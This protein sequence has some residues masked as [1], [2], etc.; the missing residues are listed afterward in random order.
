MGSKQR[1]L[2]YFR[3]SVGHV[4]TTEELAYV[5]KGAKEF[6]RRSRELRTEDGY[7][8]A[9]RF[10]GRPDLGMGEYILL[11]AERIAEPHDRHIPEPV[12]KHVYERDRNT[13]R[14]CNWNQALWTPDDPRFLELHHLEAHETG[15]ENIERNLAVVCNKC[16]DDVHAGRREREITKL[17]EHQCRMYSK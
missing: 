2:A 11:S 17:R 15:G 9:T 13:C 10:T 7:A 5:A 6:A 3:E 12:Q 16:H 14:L 8:I 1:V 4:V